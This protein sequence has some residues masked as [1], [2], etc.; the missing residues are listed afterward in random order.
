MKVTIIFSLLVLQTLASVK[1][2]ESSAKAATGKSAEETQLGQ[3]VIVYVTTLKAATNVLS[4]KGKNLLNEDDKDDNVQ[5]ELKK[6][7]GQANRVLESAKNIDKTLKSANQD[8]KVNSIVDHFAPAIR[9]NVLFSHRSTLYQQLCGNKSL[10]TVTCNPKH[11][12]LT[13]AAAL[14]TLAKSE[15]EKPRNNERASRVASSIFEQEAKE[16][17]DKS[18]EMRKKAKEY[19]D[20]SEEIV[21]KAEE[22]ASKMAAKDKKGS[23]K[24]LAE[25]KKD[26]EKMV[27]KAKKVVESFREAVSKEA[28]DVIYILNYMDIDHIGQHLKII[29]PV[30]RNGIL[31]DVIMTE[32]KREVME[33]K[34]A[35]EGKDKAIKKK[36]TLDVLRMFKYMN[37]E[38]I[39][40]CLEEEKLPSND[41]LYEKAKL[42]K[43][44]REVGEYKDSVSNSYKEEIIAKE[45]QD[46]VDV[47]SE[48]TGPDMEKCLRSVT[49]S[50]KYWHLRKEVKSMKN[51]TKSAEILQALRNAS[52]ANCEKEVN[53]YIASVND[54]KPKDIIEKE[55]HDVVEV[56]E[57]MNPSDAKKC[58]EYIASNKE[59]YPHVHKQLLEKCKKEV[60][61]YVTV[62]ENTKASDALREKEAKDVIHILKYMNKADADTCKSTL[63]QGKEYDL[64]RNKFD[65][66]KSQ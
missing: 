28:K 50:K 63:P 43:C 18:K 47:L 3:D 25:A 27:A 32:C 61:E 40:K 45:A 41:P 15:T 58:L 48:M 39:K 66:I 38:E 30:H 9:E 53:E 12:G 21:T 23:E 17:I 11:T 57:G 2:K 42:V 55:A 56:L 31:H 36:E 59:K 64:L 24:K 54:N 14:I 51:K 22:E 37:D 4:Q 26:S 60:A 8:D 62:A 49:H 35:L 65:T 5:D 29:P 6:V 44:K 10:T 1:P 52:M 34:A 20:K 7:R 19:I 13:L 46:I 33:Y 16:Y